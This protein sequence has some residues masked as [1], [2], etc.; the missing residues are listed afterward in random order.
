MLQYEEDAQ[1]SESTLQL[2]RWGVA[3]VVLWASDIARCSATTE[4]LESRGAT[5]AELLRMSDDRWEALIVDP[6]DRH[7]LRAEW[8]ALQQLRD[9]TVQRRSSDGSAIGLNSLQRELLRSEQGVAEV[10]R[11]LLAAQNRAALEAVAEG[12]VPDRCDVVQSRPM[13]R[14]AAGFVDV[15]SMRSDLFAGTFADGGRWARST[16]TASPS[17]D[18]KWESGSDVASEASQH[19][20]YDAP[21]EQQRRSPSPPSSS[22]SSEATTPTFSQPRSGRDGA[23]EDEFDALIDAAVA[24]SSRLDVL[25]QVKCAVESR[26]SGDDHP[27]TKTSNY[28][29]LCEVEMLR[30][31]VHTRLPQVNS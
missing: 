7:E 31:D 11:Q 19:D 17:T 13:L 30:N 14:D 23:E 9:H 5:G 16:A 26:R 12:A 10:Q 24:K 25:R 2:E 29:L 18:M 21:H 28:R 15:T 27:A 1:L 3:E 6:R 22:S 20:E 4:A 8:I